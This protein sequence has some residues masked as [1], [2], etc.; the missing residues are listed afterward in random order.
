[1]KNTEWKIVYTKYEG[2]AKRAIHLLS[3]EAGRYLIRESGVYRIH[4]LPCEKEG[5]EVSKNAFFVGC[6]QDSGVIREYVREDEI[7][8][9]GFLVKV[10]QSPVDEDGRFVILTAHSEQELFYAAVSFLD[11]YIPENAPHGGSNRMPDLIFDRPLPIT[12]YTERP[13]HQTRSVFTWGHSINDYRAYIDN[14]ARLKLNELILWNDYVPL[15][16]SEIVDYAH[17]YGIK[18]V[19]GYSWG[20]NEMREKSKHITAQ[21][22]ALAK[23]NAIKEYRERYADIA[24][25]GI[26]FQSFTER[27]EEIVDGKP[28]ASLVT[29]MVNEVASEL[30]KITP[31]LRLIFGLHAT[32]VKARLEEIAR[33]DPRI[34]ILWEDTG[35]F[36]YSYE[37]RVHDEGAFQET[38]AF[39]KKLLDLRGGVGVG[40]VFKGVM[41]LDW[42]KFVHQSGPYV[43]GENSE[44]VAMHDRAVRASAWREYAADWLASGARA[45]EMLRFINLNKRGEVNM[46]IAGTFDGG[47]YLPEALCAQMYRHCEADYGE[48]L[49]RVARRAS[50]TVD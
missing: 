18:V 37:S 8:S 19:L 45:A 9:D 48:M 26:Y 24:C 35:E 13:D 43:M 2:V 50:I 5:C 6:Y 30:W 44:W 40:L 4:V 47:I 27:H 31:R 36:P 17:A 38:L 29:D 49:R 22:I 10:V 34:E 23:E 1:M 41:M 20:W 21:S 15:N 42:S 28:T 32:S 39:T 7:P 14:M 46:C 12:S 11:D 33:V 16:V 3:K 25:D